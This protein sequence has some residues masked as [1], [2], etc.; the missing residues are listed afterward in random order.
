[1]RPLTDATPKPLLPVGDRPLIVHLINRLVR[2]G[3]TDL[4]INHAYMG[5][6]I[7]KTLGDGRKFGACIR[8]S[9]EQSAL[10]TGGGIRNV[11][12]SLGDDPFLVVNGDIWTD[13]PFSRL[14]DKPRRLGHI[15]LVKNPPYNIKGDFGL[16]SPETPDASVSNHAGEWLTFT[17]LGVYRPALFLDWEPGN[18]PLAQVLRRAADRGEITGERYRGDWQDI[19]TPKRLYELNQ[20]VAHES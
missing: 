6:H 3:Y 10:D 15:V 12:P 14:V 19:G 11:I 16:V 8:Y 2:E 1:M 4:T 13:Y 20:T 7:E 17:G 18:F 9:R 5:A